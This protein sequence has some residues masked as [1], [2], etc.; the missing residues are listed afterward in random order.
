M[1]SVVKRSFT[2]WLSRG[3]FFRTFSPYWVINTRKRIL[4]IVN[5]KLKKKL[6]WRKIKVHTYNVKYIQVIKQSSVIFT[7]LE[8]IGFVPSQC[9]KQGLKHIQYH[10]A[11]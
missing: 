7:T 8:K 5:L 2:P 9:N 4:T 10:K 3:L 11:L 1:K 6:I